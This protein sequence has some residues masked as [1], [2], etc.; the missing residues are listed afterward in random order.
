MTVT[1]PM[2]VSVSVMTV[3]N[4]LLRTISQTPSIS[5]N[6]NLGTLNLTWDGRA[7]EQIGLHLRCTTLFAPKLRVLSKK[8]QAHLRRYGYRHFFK[9]SLS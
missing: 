7:P 9:A 6:S 1:N 3:L 4:G 5:F 8:K 2:N